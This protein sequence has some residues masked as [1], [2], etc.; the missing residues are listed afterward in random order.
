MSGNEQTELFKYSQSSPGV[1]R[2]SK[3]TRTHNN[4]LNTSESAAHSGLVVGTTVSLVSLYFHHCLD[5]EGFFL[6][7]SCRQRDLLQ[8]THTHTGTHARARVDGRARKQGDEGGQMGGCNF[9]FVVKT[10]AREA[11]TQQYCD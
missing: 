1:K 5:T 3:H 4:K 11:M 6:A 8:W 7:P 10:S 9:M 2:N